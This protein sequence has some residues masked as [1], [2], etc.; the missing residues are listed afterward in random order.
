[1]QHISFVFL[2]QATREFITIGLPKSFTSSSA[3]I[4]VV[5]DTIDWD[6]DDSP[7]LYALRENLSFVVLL[8]MKFFSCVQN[9]D[10]IANIKNKVN[11]ELSQQDS[12]FNSSIYH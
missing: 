9:N 2:K 4:E 11:N 8:L 10:V 3:K 6:L 1:M 5:M 12:P 7:D